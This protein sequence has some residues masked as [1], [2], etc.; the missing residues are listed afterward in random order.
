MCDVEGKSCVQ[1]AAE[2]HRSLD[3]LYKLRRRAY[4]K[5]TDGAVYRQFTDSFPANVRTKI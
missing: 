4:K 2:L 3:G 1:A 5:L